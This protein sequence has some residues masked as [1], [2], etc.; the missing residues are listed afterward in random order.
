MI[1]S[2][3]R[4]QLLEL[5]SCH[6]DWKNIL[7]TATDG[8][9]ST[10][11]IA[12]LPIPRNTGTYDVKDGD[13]VKPLGGWEHKTIEPGMFF[14]RPGIYFPLNPTSQQIKDIRGRGVGKSVV[15]ENWERIMNAW[16]VRRITDTIAV[17]NVSRFCGAKTSISVAGKIVIKKDK[18]LD[19]RVFH[20]AEGN[21]QQGEPA[22]GQWIKRNVDMSFN[23]EPKRKKVSRDGV[24]L[25]LRTF[26]KH[27]ESV[28]YY[29]CIISE[30]AKELKAVTD[31]IMEQPDCDL[32]EYD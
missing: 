14:A 9:C 28:P 2:G 17:S 19:L 5:F 18:V 29:D 22:Y 30:E 20:R 23:P 10:E 15:L 21:H 8:L 11:E 27:Q 26:P 1:T 7:M 31:E 25:E 32:I 3:T 16:P 13:K 4:A 12:D 6:Q 24:T